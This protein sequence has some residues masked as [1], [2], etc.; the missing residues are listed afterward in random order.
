[1]ILNGSGYNE[2]NVQMSEVYEVLSS[3][4]LDDEYKTEFKNIIGGL[5]SIR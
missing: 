4:D 1:M 5:I 3:L 2:R